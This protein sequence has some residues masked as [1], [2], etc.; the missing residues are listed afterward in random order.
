[1][2][3]RPNDRSDSSRRS[4]PRAASTRRRVMSAC[5]PA[6]RATCARGATRT[7]CASHGRR[8]WSPASV[9]LRRRRC[10][11]R[12]TARRSRSSSRASRSANGVAS[13]S[14][15]PS[16]CCA[17]MRPSGTVRGGTRSSCSAITRMAPTCSWARRCGGWSPTAS[18]IKSGDRARSTRCSSWKKTPTARPL[19]R[20]GSGGGARAPA[21]LPGRRRGIR[22]RACRGRE[23]ARRGTPWRPRKFR[24]ERKFHRFARGEHAVHRDRGGSYGSSATLGRGSPRR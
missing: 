1:M 22:T 11:A 4:P 10:R 18:P 9:G 24:S 17:T 6:R 14:G 3:G 5:P 19:R 23:A 21:P 13:T 16:S 20:V 2:A 8:R 15:S 12:S 7:A